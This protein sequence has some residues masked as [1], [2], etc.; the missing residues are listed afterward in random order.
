M[1]FSASAS[2]ST[3]LITQFDPGNIN[4]QDVTTG[5]GG[6]LWF[7]ELDRD[8]IGVMAPDGRVIA[9]YGS[10]VIDP[11]NGQGF[12]GITLGPD[13][14]IWFT[15]NGNNRNTSIGRITPSGVITKFPIPTSRSGVSNITSG[16]SDRSI[17]F[18]ETAA[19]KI[20]RINV[21]Q[22]RLASDGSTIGM[23][24]F[25]ANRGP[26]NPCSVLGGTPAASANGPLDLVRGSDGNIW[27]TQNLSGCIGRITSSG[28]LT[29]FKIP[30]RRNSAGAEI[31]IGPNSITAGPGG[32]LYFTENGD[33]R[34]GS[35][36]TAGAI[37]EFAFTGAVL[38]CGRGTSPIDA[39]GAYGLDIAAGADGNLWFTSNSG[40]DRYISRVTPSGAITDFSRVGAT[41]TNLTL[42]PDNN[43]W[44]SDSWTE[45]SRRIFGASRLTV[46]TTNSDD[47]VRP[48]GP[49]GPATVDVKST[50]TDVKSETTSTTG[51]TTKTSVQVQPSSTP[52]TCASLST[53]KARAS[54]SRYTFLNGGGSVRLVGRE[55]GLLYRSSTT[56]TF[57]LQV[58]RL[59]GKPSPAIKSVTFKVNGSTVKTAKSAPYS[60]KINPS[61]LKGDTVTVTATVKPK[62]GNQ[63]RVGLTAGV[64]TCK[65]AGFRV[66]A[67]SK[68]KRAKANLVLSATTG[69]T[70]KDNPK[71]TDATFTLGSKA[72]VKKSLL[73]KTIGTIL[74]DSTTG[75]D[76]KLTLK[77]PKAKSGSMTVLNRNG[78]KVVLKA[79]AKPT[80]V[81]S[82]IT[83]LS[84][85]VK[86]LTISLNN[87]KTGLIRNPNACSTLLNKTKLTDTTRTSVSLSQ[88][89]KLCTNRR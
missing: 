85:D 10:S 14:N 84:A 79:G 1:V 7:T 62:K 30:T 76:K 68:Q 52:T 11:F 59:A 23:V 16:G 31:F 4:I 49:R 33:A 34:I 24:E 27:F 26:G 58:R 71:L 36:T 69:G 61:K 60:V 47:C 29:E 32:K 77:L 83:G 35:I 20:G 18:T 82:G 3:G 67:S 65:P 12:G 55:G 70:D 46:D 56:E 78:L 51:L 57:K 37:E 72:A 88:N 6:N 53:A 89:V 63:A 74:L 64:R 43:I 44:M 5:P 81:V 48:E 19:G 50:T 86:A 80:I 15:D 22:A 45:G 39:R 40:S 73:G 21:D 28:A 8:Q 38:P 25:A 66:T 54:I 13:G 75:L 87:K 17:W 42:G 9:E 41:P 2:A